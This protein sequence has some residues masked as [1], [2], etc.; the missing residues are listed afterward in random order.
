MTSHVSGARWPDCPRGAC[1]LSPNR[2][3]APG[4]RGPSAPYTSAESV[5]DAEDAWTTWA[6]VANAI[7]E[8][9][10]QVDIL[11]PG[12]L[13][14]WDRTA[15]SRKT[16]SGAPN[17][18]RYWAHLFAQPGDD[19]LG[20]ASNGH[21]KFVASPRNLRAIATCP[22]ASRT[23]TNVGECVFEA[24]SM[25]PT[26]SGKS[27]TSK[28]GCPEMP[29]ENTL[30]PVS[31][32]V[33]SVTTPRWTVFSV[34]EASRSPKWVTMIRLAADVDDR[35][36]RGAWRGV[37]RGWCLRSLTLLRELLMATRRDLARA[38]ARDAIN[39]R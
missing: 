5:A 32:I 4:W 18:C 11:T 28:L 33:V 39:L 7:S 22:A 17:S 10:P 13:R 29:S 36:T 26:S 38:Y 12:T 3:N 2:T 30:A 16:H 14:I 21:S 34:L 37:Q 25:A 1:R 6:A 35:E 23:R 19:R 9:E 8:F 20:A 27:A 24:A 31:I 15:K